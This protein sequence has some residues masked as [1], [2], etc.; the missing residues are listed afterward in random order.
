M[1]SS[2]CK[3]PM[4]RELL[5]SNLFYLKVK[6]IFNILLDFMFFPCISI[7]FFPIINE[8]YFLL[9]SPDELFRFLDL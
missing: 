1:L 5:D 8:L 7:N 3:L 4:I 2:L 9:V 6:M